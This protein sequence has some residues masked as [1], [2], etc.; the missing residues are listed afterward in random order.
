MG[1]AN[2]WPIS[3]Y[4][5][6]LWVVAQDARWSNAMEP[7]NSRSRRK[8][9]SEIEIIQKIGREFLLVVLSLRIVFAQVGC[10]RFTHHRLNAVS[11]HNARRACPVNLEFVDPVWQGLKQ[12]ASIGLV[13]VLFTR[14]R[15]LIAA[16]G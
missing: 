10:P 16:V 14:P 8:S 13:L 4:A 11:V 12:T 6:E 2:R 5:V 1:P 9:A 7:T 15:S 3:V